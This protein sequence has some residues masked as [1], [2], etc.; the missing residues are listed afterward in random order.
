MKIMKNVLNTIDFFGV[1]FLFKYQN[2]NKYSTSFGGLSFTILCIFI[3]SVLIFNFI[4][5]LNRK[6]YNIIYYTTSMTGTEE[7]KLYE[8]GTTFAIGFE[9]Y[10]DED[11][12]KAT[13]LL[14]LDIYFITLAIDENNNRNKYIENLSTHPCNY[15]DFYYNFNDSFNYLQLNNFHCMDKKNNTVQGIFTDKIFTYYQF[16]VSAKNNSISHYKKIDDYL[17][18]NDCKLQFYYTSNSFDLNDYGM[19]LKPYIDALFLQLSPILFLKTNLYFMNQYFQDDKLIIFTEDEDKAKMTSMFSRIESYSLYKGTNRG[20][21]LP[22]DYQN[23]ANIYIRADTKKTEIKRKYEK[24]TEFFAGFSSLF[25][26]S[27]NVLNIVIYY[28]NNFYAELSIIRKV[29]FL[30]DI[31]N[32]KFDTFKK[33][34][35]IKRLISLTD[36]FKD[37]ISQIS[38][39]YLETSDKENVNVKD[40]SSDLNSLPKDE[41]IKPKEKEISKKVIKRKIIVKKKVKK[42]NYSFLKLTDNQKEDSQNIE[43]KSFST[44][45]NSNNKINSNIDNLIGNGEAK[46]EKKGESKIENKNVNFQKIKFI[47]NLPEVIIISFFKCCMTKNMSYKSNLISKAR[48]FI[49]HKLDIVIY[50]RNMILIDIINQVL[51]EDNKKDIFNFLSRPKLSL[52]SNRRY[53]DNNIFYRDFTEANIDK[54]YQEILELTQKSDLKEFEKKLINLTNKELKMII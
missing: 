44:K 5:F 40:Y 33:Q 21:V 24:L 22:T 31:E 32:N 12:T 28:V 6:N 2:K 29:F 3:I 8:S 50:L 47:Y 10:D 16:T 23:Y 46:E 25:V 17:L 43:R 51:L 30:K 38:P 18:R 36:P 20:E 11:G 39:K 54:F 49:F 26:V 53:D 15:E 37:K 35:E 42:R 41:K 34:K 13:D 48:S 1:P 52:N 19:P 7:I 4:S 45:I 27:Y 14:K 9:C